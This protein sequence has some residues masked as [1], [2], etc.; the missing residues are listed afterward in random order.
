MRWSRPFPHPSNSSDSPPPCAVQ[1]KKYLS[2]PCES[3]NTAVWAGA[4]SYVPDNR[5]PEVRGQSDAP[6]CGT[7]QR[8][9][10]LSP[11]RFASKLYGASLQFQSPHHK[12]YGFPPEFVSPEN[13]SECARR[14]LRTAARVHR[15][16]PGTLHADNSFQGS[17]QDEAWNRIQKRCVREAI[18]NAQCHQ[19][20][21]V[22]VFH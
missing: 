5:D 17:K 9:K 3:E 1:P 21:E 18:P 6:G 4:A 13:S 15:Q 20:R 12:P 7:N 19:L 10:R 14:L 11:Q 2:I 22:L 8:W 16:K